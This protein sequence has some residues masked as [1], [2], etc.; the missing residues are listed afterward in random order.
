MS[1]TALSVSGT[2]NYKICVPI[3]MFYRD[4]CFNRGTCD[5]CTKECT[6]DTHQ[7]RFYY[8]KRRSEPICM[9]GWGFWIALNFVKLI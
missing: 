9:K 4:D 8:D 5:D 2:T 1:E 3:K 7:V 6:C